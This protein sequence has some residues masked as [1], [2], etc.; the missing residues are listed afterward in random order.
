MI[1]VPDLPCLRYPKH[2]QWEREPP[3][4]ALRSDQRSADCACRTDPLGVGFTMSLIATE[5]LIG[6]DAAY[7]VLSGLWTLAQSKYFYLAVPLFLFS[8]AFPGAKLLLLLYAWFLSMGTRSR[9]RLLD[10]LDRIGKWSMLD[11]YVVLITA[12]AL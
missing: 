4:E 11:V 6:S 8:V 1:R 10:W 5:K 9:N 2:P 7:S 12:G 3:E